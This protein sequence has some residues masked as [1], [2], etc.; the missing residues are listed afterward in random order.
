MWRLNG[1]FENTEDPFENTEDPFDLPCEKSK[2]HPIILAILDKQFGNT[3]SFR[4]ISKVEI[5]NQTLFIN[6]K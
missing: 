1:E 4:K 2:N 3:F 6:G 5:E